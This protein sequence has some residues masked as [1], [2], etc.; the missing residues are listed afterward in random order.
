MHFLLAFSPD[1][2]IVPTQGSTISEN[3]SGLLIVLITANARIRAFGNTSASLD[4]NII[5]PLENDWKF[6]K[7]EKI[8]RNR[9]IKITEEGKNAAEFLI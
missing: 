2:L 4:K 9:W 8:G 5:A 7:V 3:S 1:S 6:I